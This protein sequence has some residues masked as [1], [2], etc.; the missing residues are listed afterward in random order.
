MNKNTCFCMSRKGKENCLW[1]DVPL[2][3]KMTYARVVEA[4]VTNL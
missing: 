3:L 1:K 2:T 4:S